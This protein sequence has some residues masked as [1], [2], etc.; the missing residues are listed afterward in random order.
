MRYFHSTPYS[1]FCFSNLN[2]QTITLFCSKL[3]HSVIQDSDRGMENITNDGD[4]E[5]KQGFMKKEK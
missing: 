3:K 2:S 4:E 1:I 5:G